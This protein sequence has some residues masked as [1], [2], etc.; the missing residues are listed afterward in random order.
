MQLLAEVWKFF[1]Y[2]LHFAQPGDQY[3]AAKVLKG[4]DGAGRGMS[5]KRNRDR[6]TSRAFHQAFRKMSLH[7]AFLHEASSL[8]TL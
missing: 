5:K 3:P 2:T 7:L 4:F 6:R 1:G 8:Q